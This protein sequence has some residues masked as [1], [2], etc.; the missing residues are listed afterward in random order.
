MI[1]K[2]LK[3]PLYVA[4]IDLEKVYDRVDR[5]K[6]LQSLIRKGLGKQMLR[7][8][9]NM[10]GLTF[11]FIMGCGELQSTSGIRQGATSSSYVFI[12]FI[13]DIIEHINSLYRSDGFLNGI[14]ILFH[15]DDALILATSHEKL[16]EKLNSLD[17]KLTEMSLKMNYKKCKFMCFDGIFAKEHHLQF[18]CLCF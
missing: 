13:N 10:Y 7:A 14:N 9:V 8:L 4:F 3:L 1:A 5:V 11:S 6:M 17:E 16:K 2:R 12:L 18:F 15:A